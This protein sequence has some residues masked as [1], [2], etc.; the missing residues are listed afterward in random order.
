MLLV[1]FSM[2]ATYG[3]F[4]TTTDCRDPH[5]MVITPSQWL[6]ADALPWHVSM[7]IRLHPL[8]GN[9]RTRSRHDFQVCWSSKIQ[10][11]TGWLVE[12]SKSSC[13]LASCFRCNDCVREVQKWP[14]GAAMTHFDME[15]EGRNVEQSRL[16]MRMW[17]QW[18][19]C[20]QR[21]AREAES[22]ERRRR[23][24]WKKSKKEWKSYLE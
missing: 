12:T 1:W 24:T 18:W 17:W 23:S 5:Q 15:Y 13:S 16:W 9:N 20:G 22:L 21:D 3:F 6:L 7:N 14:K 10:Y 2:A 4:W 19:V 8:V 11:S